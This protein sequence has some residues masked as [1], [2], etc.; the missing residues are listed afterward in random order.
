MLGSSK[1]MLCLGGWFMMEVCPRLSTDINVHSWIPVS[2]KARPC[3][4]H[5]LLSSS[6]TPAF[7]EVAFVTEPSM[8]ELVPQ[9]D[10]QTPP[11]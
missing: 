10:L 1:G 3:Y 7:L 2:F 6:A 5:Y 8:T 11:L 9:Q 4:Y